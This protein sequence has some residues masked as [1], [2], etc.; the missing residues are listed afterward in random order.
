MRIYDN[1]IAKF[2]SVDTL[3]S[4]YSELTAYQFAS[5]TSISVID[6]DGLEAKLA[7]ACSVDEILEQINL[8]EMQIY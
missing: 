4:S 3:A 6:L 7:I 8:A 1:R 5:N 2:L